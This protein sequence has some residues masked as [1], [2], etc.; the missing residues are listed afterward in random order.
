MWLDWLDNIVDETKNVEETMT[1]EEILH[2]VL[3][4]SSWF[5]EVKF[6][7]A[8]WHGG[9]HKDHGN[10]KAQFHFDINKF[11]E[12]FDPENKKWERFVEVFGKKRIHHN[13]SM[14][15]MENQEERSARRN[16]EKVLHIF[17]GLLADVLENDKERKQ[18]KIPSHE[19]NKRINNKLHNAR[20]K[21][22]RKKPEIE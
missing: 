9:Q 13:D 15:I 21:Q 18:T 8:S 5:W 1:N 4:K 17:R 22:N 3:Q 16:E 2:Y 6:V 12:K 7:H 20:K 19:K 10:S 11:F 14:L